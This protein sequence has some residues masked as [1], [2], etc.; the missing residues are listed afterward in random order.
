M[1]RMGLIKHLINNTSLGTN[2]ISLLPIRV[3]NN[4]SLGITLDIT[5]LLDMIIETPL[6]G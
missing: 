2:N 4:I 5:L 6:M 3:S 1:G